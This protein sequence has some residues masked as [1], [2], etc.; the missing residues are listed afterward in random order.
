MCTHL[1]LLQ[2]GQLALDELAA[3]G[4][5]LVREEHALDVVVLVLDDAGREAGVGLAVWLEVRIHVLDGDRG[6]AGDALV[7]AWDAEAALILGQ[8]LLAALYDTSVDEGLLEPLALE[9][10][11]GHGIGVDDEE[12]NGAPDLRRR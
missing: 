9:V 12:A 8:R 7:D 10:A 3:D 2:V 1:T 6:R 4:G 11:L 5:D